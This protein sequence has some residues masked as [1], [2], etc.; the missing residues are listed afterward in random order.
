[1]KRWIVVI[2]FGV[3][4]CTGYLLFA[5]RDAAA[6]P[7]ARL[8]PGAR[9]AARTSGLPGAAARPV[10]QAAAAPVP[11]ERSG[12]GAPQVTETGSGPG[13]AVTAEDMREQL[14]ASFAALPLASNDVA[15]R[16][17]LGMRAVLP[18]GSSVRSVECRGSLCR[19]ETQHAG[20]DDFR[21]FVQRAFQGQPVAPVSNGPVFVNLL[22]EPAPG[23]PVVAVAYVGREG[24][25]LPFSNPPA[26]PPADPLASR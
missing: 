18:A 24:T 9:A 26:G 15:H 11:D 8:E 25:A 19:V 5:T 7:G 21:D 14:Q 12:P 23:K 13:S 1:M 6:P 2:V 3:L 16:L 4:G 22:E 20:F 10:L 17:E